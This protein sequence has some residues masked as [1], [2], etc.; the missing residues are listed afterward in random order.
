MHLTQDGKKRL[1]LLLMDPCITVNVP[2]GVCTTGSSLKHPHPE[3][4][5]SET[6]TTQETITKARVTKET[7]TANPTYYSQLSA[8]QRD[9]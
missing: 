2:G 9:Y 5:I 3:V 8:H 6:I 7:V 4:M 1:S